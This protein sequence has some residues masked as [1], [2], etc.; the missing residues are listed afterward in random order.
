M[1]SKLMDALN[2]ASIA[3]EGQKRKDNITPYIVHSFGVGLIL[4]EYGYSEEVVIAG[5][6]HDVAED[7]KFSLID[8]KEKFGERVTKI[9][10][11]VTE[12]KNISPKEE[13]LKAYLQNLKKSDNDTKAVCAADMLHN[14]RSL[15]SELE[16]KYDIWGALHI[17]KEKY[18]EISYKK[19][20]VIKETL[21]D[22]LVQE[23][24]KA[25]EEIS[26]YRQ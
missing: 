7:T 24:E 16:R 12:D 1:T 11:G 26:R 22:K 3:H 10:S 5:I 9:I 19:L 18:L 21:N 25:L 17:N 23:L 13:M 8:I 6:L 4:L 20:A 15:M 2:F 14:R